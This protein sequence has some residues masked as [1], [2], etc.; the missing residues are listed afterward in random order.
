MV[1]YGIYRTVPA[2]EGA[3]DELLATGFAG[4]SIFVL[5]PKNKNRVEFAKRKHRHVPRGTGEG[6][7]AN[8]P[9]DGTIGF[10]DPEGFATVPGIGFHM[11]TVRLTRVRCMGQVTKWAFPISG[12]TNGS[13]AA[14]S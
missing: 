9:L 13:S 2:A 3:V 5:D 11:T 6:R 12:A 10:T 8:L 1:V 7:T 14:R 4:E